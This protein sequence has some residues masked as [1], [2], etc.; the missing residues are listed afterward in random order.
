MDQPSGKPFIAAMNRNPLA[1]VVAVVHFKG[2][3]L[4]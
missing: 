4:L 2:I 1:I 3:T